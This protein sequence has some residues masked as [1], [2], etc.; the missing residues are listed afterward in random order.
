MLSPQARA[1]GFLPVFGTHDDRLAG[2][3]MA[4]AR[5]RGWAPDEFEF[6]MLYG[7]RTDWQLALR[8][9]GYNLR[10]YLPFGADWWPYAIRRVG[11]IP[12][13]MAVGAIP[14]FGWIRGGSGLETGPGRHGRI[15]F[16][17][18]WRFPNISGI[19]AP[20]CPATCSSP[21]CAPIAMGRISMTPGRSARS[22]MAPA[23]TVRDAPH[24]AQ[25][26]DLVVIAP[27]DVHTGG[28]SE[29]PLGYRMLYVEP[30]WLDDH[31]RAL[32]GA[33]AAFD[34]P[35]IR[36]PALCAQWL[37]ALAPEG[38]DEAGRAEHLGRAFALREHARGRADGVRGRGCLRP[39]ARAHGAGPGLRAGPGGAGPGA[40]PPPHHAGQA[41]RAPLWP[42]AA[43]LAAQLARGAARELL[44]GGLPLADAAHAVGFADQAHMTRVFKQVYGSTPGVFRKASVAVRLP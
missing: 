44:R 10:V 12:Q 5:E 4:L 19:A 23:L 25:A 7:V 32:L 36:D 33:A 35:V 18:R 30:S 39:A 26:G 3:L 24:L 37:A 6:E 38:M 17:H 29:T 14:E 40:G 42:A 28:T 43:G 13:R 20:A 34:G 9:M 21:T 8:A 15:W 2:A 22:T 41:V 31:A 1:A 27:G 16:L 11:S